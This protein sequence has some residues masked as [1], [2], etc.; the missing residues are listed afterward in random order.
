MAVDNS[1]ILDKI[2]LSG[3]NDYQQRIPKTTQNGI[4]ATQA[5]LFAEENLPWYNQFVAALVNRIGSTYVHQQ[6]W[7]NP[8]AVFKKDALRYGD[9][10]QEIA[11]KWIKAHSYADDR[12]DVFKV[13][14]PDSEVWFHTVNRRDFYPIT[15]NDEEL[16]FAFTESMGLN[17]YVAS[18][19]QT[20]MNSDQYDEYRIMLELLAYYE[21]N[22]GFFKHQINWQP[23]S[24]ASAQELMYE[25]KRYGKLFKFPSSRYN[26][27]LIEDIPVFANMD[28]LVVLVTPD[29]SAS[30]D[31]YALAAAYHMEK[32]EIQQRIVEVDEFPIPNAV[33]I[34][35]TQ[36]FFQCRDRLNR[37]TSQYNPLTLGTNY[38]LHRWGSYSVSPFVP[39]VLFTT[40]AGSSIPTVTMEPSALNLTSAANTVV[41]GG[42]VL[43]SADLAGTVDPSGYPVDVLPDAAVFSVGVTRSGAAVNSP[44]TYVDEYGVLHAS[45]KLQTGDIITVT[46]TSA[47]VNPSGTT[48]TYTDSVTVTVA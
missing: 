30:I 23:K 47:Y 25:L 17:S 37:N 11:T 2:W 45:K 5:A 46:A 9:K 24:T 1:T 35:T 16:S 13:Y 34:L 20:P 12:E 28:E 36:D 3:T 33:A 15:V 43:L 32:E 40:D 4:A 48:T 7:T 38:F 31:V 21:H 6:S 39:A 14:R 26:A 22:F 27:G 29:V 8:L 42:T 18:I 44:R 19:M 41:A 10:T